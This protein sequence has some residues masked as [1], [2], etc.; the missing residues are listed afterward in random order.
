MGKPRLQVCLCTFLLTGYNPGFLIGGIPKNIG[1]SAR[2]A[3]SEY[4]VI[5]AVNMTPHFLTRDQN[6]YIKPIC[7]GN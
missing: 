4:F 5:E 1:V 6:S 7:C 2:F 3:D